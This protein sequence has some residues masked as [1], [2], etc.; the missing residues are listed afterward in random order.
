MSLIFPKKEILYAPMLG[1]LGGGSSRGFGRGGGEVPLFEFTSH[2][3][4]SAGAGGPFGPSQ[5]QVNS[6]YPS[7]ISSNVT[8]ATQGH[9]TFTIP[10]TGNYRIEAYGAVCYDGN[11]KAAYIQATRKLDQGQTI[12]IMVGQRGQ[13][14]QYNNS[15]HGGTFVFFNATDTYP[16]VVAG[17]AG[18]ASQNNNPN[19][20]GS[21]SDSW[22]QI[23]EA[24]GYGRTASSTGANS[25]SQLRSVGEG[26]A[27]VDTTSN[28]YA[29]GA[30]GGWLSDGQYNSTGCT[31]SQYVRGGRAPRNNGEG[32]YGQFDNTARY[33]GFG[34]G[35]GLHGG[36]SSSANGGGGGYSGGAA[37]EGCCDGQGGGGGSYTDSLCTNVSK[38]QIRDTGTNNGAGY[39]RLTYL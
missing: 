26:G 24:G 38:T 25:Q 2:L 31:Y 36:C 37:A 29:S 18:G 32:G 34:G 12:T 33:G 11:S 8:V 7:I 23:T 13:Q 30:G 28:N 6:S 19:G 17:G 21:T 1:T 16:I 22:G 10:S 14:S 4:T 20:S 39:C 5:S 9:Q 3:F 15:G 27:D 35:G